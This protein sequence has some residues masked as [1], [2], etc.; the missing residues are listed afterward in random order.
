MIGKGTKVYHPG[1]S[2]I[3]PDAIIGEGCKIH[4]LVWIGGGV[5]IGNNV[6]IEAFS[7]IPPGT[8]IED[9]VFIGPRVTILNDKHPPSGGKWSPVIIR[10]GAVLG[11]GAIILPGVEIGAYAV[12]GAGAVVT[13]SVFGRTTVVGNPARLHPVKLGVPFDA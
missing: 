12:V 7:F 8:V 2:M 10:R 5:R 1:L 13:K 3:H 4:A 11:G 9:D 6:K